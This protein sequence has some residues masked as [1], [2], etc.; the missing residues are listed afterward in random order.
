[1]NLLK[2]NT[3]SIRNDGQSI[4]AIDLIVAKKALSSI[5]CSSLGLKVVKVRKMKSYRLTQT[6]KG[7]KECF[8]HSDCSKGLR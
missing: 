5:S 4:S 6:S 1:M 7:K 8:H 3:I 2:V